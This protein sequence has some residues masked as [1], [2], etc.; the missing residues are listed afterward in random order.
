MISRLLIS[1]EYA[2]SAALGIPSHLASC[3]ITVYS[4]TDKSV[5]SPLNQVAQ[6]TLEPRHQAILFLKVFFQLGRTC[7]HKLVY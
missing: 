2:L 4:S 7:F 6:L 1:A 3:S 5:L